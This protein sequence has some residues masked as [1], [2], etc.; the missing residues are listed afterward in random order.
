[1]SYWLNGHSEF[2]TW[3]DDCVEGQ[4][5]KCSGGSSFRARGSPRPFFN[6]SAPDW[7]SLI[8]RLLI[9]DASEEKRIKGFF[10]CGFD[11]FTEFGS[12]TRNL[13]H[14]VNWIFSGVGQASC[15]RDLADTAREL[16]SLPVAGFRLSS[17][18]VHERQGGP[19][20]GP[21][22]PAKNG[23]R[24]ATRQP[25]PKESERE[26]KSERKRESERES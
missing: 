16:A 2:V 11:D 18:V 14:P 3:V 13:G 10:S 6:S 15:K 8:N 26:R 7:P 19:R 20:A 17:V 5:E 1:M 25:L 22:A 9:N 24:V 4:G 21:K 12:F 23:K